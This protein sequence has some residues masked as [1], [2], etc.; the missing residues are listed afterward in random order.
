MRSISTGAPVGDVVLALLV[1]LVRHRRPPPVA[2]V[3]R[4]FTQNS[5]QKIADRSGETPSFAAYLPVSGLQ[6]TVEDNGT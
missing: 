2:F 3:Y 5:L 6:R 1:C 4:E